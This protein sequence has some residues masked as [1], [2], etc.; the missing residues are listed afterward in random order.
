MN[1]ADA[2]QKLIAEEY[3]RID[4]KEKEKKE[5]KKDLIKDSIFAGL[6]L[7]GIMASL[8]FGLNSLSNAAEY[9]EIRDEKIIEIISSSEYQLTKEQEINE[10]IKSLQG[11]SKKKAKKEII[12]FVEDSF[13]NSSVYD[14]ASSHSPAD[15]ELL[16]E[17]KN[18]AIKNG[19]LTLS[20]AVMT[21]GCAASTYCH[22]ANT[23]QDFICI[24]KCNNVIGNANE[25]IKIYQKELSKENL[26]I[27]NKAR[28]KDEEYIIE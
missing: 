13:S 10:L 27:A 26:R 21:I 24:N 1:K 4:T 28:K 16:D 3:S 5:C 11:S 8:V 22:G 15:A 6:A 20:A 17:Y 19:L 7:A 9:V 12:G 23:I 2:F 18:N 14:F 25:T